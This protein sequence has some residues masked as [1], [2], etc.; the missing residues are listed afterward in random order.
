MQINRHIRY[1][2]IAII[3]LCSMPMKAQNISLFSSKQGLSNSSIRSIYEDTRHN[4]WITTLNGLNR[5]DG[6]KMNVYRHDDADSTSLA[7][8]ESTCV[9]EYDKDRILV[10]TDR[11]MQIYSYSTNR[12]IPLPIKAM[13]SDDELIVRIIRAYRLN[14][15]KILVCFAGYGCGEVRENVNGQLYVKQTDKYLT[16]KDNLN[17]IQ[18]YEDK[19]QRLWVINSHLQ[20]YR[21]TGEGKFKHYPAFSDAVKMCMSSSGKTYVATTNHGLYIYDTKADTFRQIATAEECGLVYSISPWT[22]GRLFICSDG[23]GLRIYDEQTHKVTQSSFQVGDFNIATSNVKDA[24]SDS[25]GNVWVGIYLKG[26]VMKPVSQ[27]AFE[28]IGRNSITRNTIGTNSIVSLAPATDGKLW[29]ATDNSGLYLTSADGSSSIHINP[30]ENPGMPRTFTAICN[31]LLGTFFDGL[32]R[33]DGNTVRLLNKDIQQIFDIQPA[34][35]GNYWIASMGHGIYLYNPTTNTFFNYGDDYN[36]KAKEGERIGN[37]YVSCI[38]QYGNLLAYGTQDGLNICNVKAGKLSGTKKVI[39]QTAI[40][41]FTKVGETIWCATNKGLYGVNIKTLATERY[42]TADGL[43]INSLKSITADGN[44]LWIGTDRGLVCFDIKTHACNSFFD[45]DGLQDNEFA[46][47]ASMKAGDCLYFGGISGLTYFN[48]KDISKSQGAGKSMHLRLVDLIVSN[49]YVHVGDKSDGYDIM[50]QHIDDADEINLAYTDNHFS[51]Q[52]QVDGVSNQHI[53]YEYSINGE[54]WK[55]E[56]QSVDRLVFDNMKPGTYNIKVRA[57][58][59][60][61][62]SDERTIRIIIHAPWYSSTLAKFC[63]LI[64]FI[65]LGWLAYEYTKRQVRARKVIMRHRQEKQL[66]EARVQ[67]FMNISHEIR[68]PMTLILAPLEKLISSDKDTDR[69]RSYQLMKQ[70]SNRI[71][72]LINQMM[73]VRKIEQGKYILEYK[74][75]DIVS[76][77]QNIFDV[78]QTNAQNR[79]IKY[80]FIHDVDTLTAY[81]DPENVDKIVMN[82][83][84]NAFKFTSDMGHIT[85]TLNAAKEQ[86]NGQTEAEHELSGQSVHQ[87]FIIKVADSGVG[88]PDSE[89]TKVFERFYS[90]SQ[91]NGYIG[92]GIG[93]NLT[94][95]LVHLHNGDISIED[96]MTGKGTI[97]VVDLP[98]GDESMVEKNF[99]VEEQD[100]KQVQTEQ[101]SEAKT[102]AAPVLEIEKPLDTHNKKILLVEDDEAIRQYVHTELSKD[103]VIHECTNG[104][105]AWNYII[106]HP[107]KVNLIISDIMMPVM[108]GM[109]LCQKV[110]SNFNT[111]HLPIILM[112]ALGSDADRIAGITN[113]ADAYVSKPFNIDVLRSTAINLM[114]TRMLLQGKFHGEKQEEEHI[115]NVEMESPDEH[116]MKRVMKCINDNMDNPDLSVEMIAD[117]VGISRV[118]FYRK[119]KDLTGQSPRDY[120]KYVRLKKA[121]KLLK[122]KPNL[123]ITSVSIAV[124]FKS[125]STFS[126]NFKTLFGKSPSEWSC[127]E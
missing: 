113:G 46:L 92:T 122:E 71:L 101:P 9:L 94:S 25:F 42:T 39:S 45:S 24:I 52:L 81:V 93:L 68:T 123:D 116:L 8:D 111:N 85:L 27:S 61:M 57:R 114:K 10:G 121:A 32:Y 100:E 7:H 56:D 58:G 64:L 33:L 59:F 112:T 23:G 80:E 43:P 103:F 48:P 110:K 104:E 67:F 115:D 21:M 55:T 37:K 54:D 47:R 86:T 89:K 12:F 28:Y 73:D 96:N 44:R 5:Y 119:M 13:N 70:N 29:I 26:V 124:G 109:T 127:T 1:I 97:F 20:L 78:F 2:I 63:Y 77:L 108:D 36:A 34:T 22:F 118:H 16:S 49:R 91:K 40:T 11:G 30:D 69:Q 88:I 87:S 83:L 126:S 99:S 17:P 72:R 120:L 65:L 90:S 117:K 4:I 74:K 62:T 60:N 41:H 98:V 84:S 66:N 35:D 6:V 51:I 106:D 14:S 82:L 76:L 79:K 75:V 105:E 53:T 19:Y 125:L 31:G 102:L 18:F 95:M 38:R 3:A 15:G 50:L 107:G